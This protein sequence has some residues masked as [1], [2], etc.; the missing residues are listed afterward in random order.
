MTAE[1]I[2]ARLTDMIRVMA[3]S[4]KGIE[5]A[6]RSVDR[7]AYAAE[8]GTPFPSEEIVISEARVQ[9][10]QA[11]ATLVAVHDNLLRAEQ[12]LREVGK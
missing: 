7:V 11:I 5:R 4:H 9:L 3:G 12:N 8:R 1:H 10:R 2:D 6:A